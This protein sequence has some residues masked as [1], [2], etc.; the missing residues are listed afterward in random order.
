MNDH[1]SEKMSGLLA[2]M[3][4]DP[5]D[6]P[7]DADLVL[8][9]TCSVREKA[10]HKVFSELGRL[11]QVKESR[12]AGAM[13]IGVAGCLAQQEG[14]KIFHRAPFVDFVMGTQAL[15][16]LPRLVEEAL[17]GAGRAIDVGFYPDGHIFPFEAIRHGRTA[18]ALV[19]IIEGC[20]HACTFC[21]VPATRGAQR[22]RPS[23]DI[24]AE[25]EMLVG[26][27]FREIEL[28]GQNVNGYDGGCT[29][30][31]LL[32]RVAAVGGLEWIRFTT[33]HPMDFTRDLADA[34][35]GTPK[36]APFL[37]LPVQSGS[38]GVLRRMGRGYTAREYMERVGY[39]GEG[40]G[41][42]CLST[43]FMVGFPG[44]TDDDFEAT[45]SILEEA[46][47]D[48][49][50]SFVY[51]PRPGTP[52]LRLG[53][54]VPEGVKRERLAR[55]QARQA[56]LTLQSHA[57]E[58]GKVVP[59]R[60]ESSGPREGGLWLARTAQ[61]RN[62]RLGSPSGRPLPFGRLVDARITAAGPH[63]LRGEAL[64]EP[65]EMPGEAAGGRDGGVDLPGA[66]C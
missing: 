61:W 63:W 66:N 52:A 36:V 4:L 16:Q 1:D 8:L 49:S 31:E 65:G 21:V 55:L 2:A 3:G 18:K 60:V 46:R 13:L 33:S 22:H 38:D 58:V 15:K 54:D 42:M 48:A 35:T 45:M 24:V 27:G 50:F 62:V 25:V 41:G 10:A 53:D 47:F 12:A 56:E 28:L 17:S 43:D 30:A 20:D 7:G 57:R 44:E 14:E 9:N 23:G 32:R 51:S 29:F 37:H 64:G 40:R 34:I 5:A 6:G 26:R 19:T 11:R 59:V 39:L